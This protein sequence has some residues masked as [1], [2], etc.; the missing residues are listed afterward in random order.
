MVRG[1]LPVSLLLLLL[2]LLL[3]G[4]TQLLRHPSYSKGKVAFSYLGD[5]WIANEAGSA[6]Q[7]LTVHK[8]RD[9]HPR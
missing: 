7:R 4:E 3:R 1:S 2:P 9:I 8:A 5:V 6:L